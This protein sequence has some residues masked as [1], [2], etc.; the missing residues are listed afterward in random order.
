[1]PTKPFSL[2]REGTLKRTSV[3]HYTLINQR[4]FGHVV[5]IDSQ[6][7]CLLTR[8]SRWSRNGVFTAPPRNTLLKCEGTRPPA[9]DGMRQKDSGRDNFVGEACATNSHHTVSSP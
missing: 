5:G 6:V 3:I 1:V 8:Q 9:S 2:S 4:G 7:W